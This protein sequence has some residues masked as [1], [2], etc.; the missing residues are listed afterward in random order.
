MLH[1]FSVNTD[2]REANLAP[3]AEA[4]LQG[5]V[6]HD[7]VTGLDALRLWLAQSRG[8]VPLWPLFLFLAVLALVGESLY[9]NWLAGRRAQGAEEHIKTGRLN[10]RRI[11]QL[12][13]GDENAEVKPEEEV[14]P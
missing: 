13:R 4:A 14:A 1:Q 10:K 7:A 8:L 3:I 2:P 9:S 5:I 12:Y 6:A 11:G